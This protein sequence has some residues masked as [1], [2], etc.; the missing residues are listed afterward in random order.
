MGSLTDEKGGPWIS[1]LADENHGSEEGDGNG[2]KYVHLC[3]ITSKAFNIGLGPPA[4]NP[5][6]MVGA[7][8]YGWLR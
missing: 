8:S 7:Q 4:K 3:K 2:V 1:N 5:G 6:M